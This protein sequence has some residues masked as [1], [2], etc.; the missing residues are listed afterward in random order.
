MR[1]LQWVLLCLLCTTMACAESAKKAADALRDSMGKSQFVLRNFSGEDK[2][3]ASWTGTA[4]EL[5][6][7]RWKTL[8]VL[9]VDSVKLHG[10]TLTLGCVRHVAIR[11]NGG[12]VALYPRA[13]DIEIE[14]DLGN[15]DPAA[16][17]A[18]VKEALFY[19]SIQDAL[20]AIPESMQKWIPARMD[21]NSPKPANEPEVLGA[22]ECDCAAKDRTGCNAINA[23]T[24]GMIPPKYLSGRDPEFS[25]AAR[26]ETLDAHVLVGLKVDESGHPTDVWVLRPVGVGLDEAAAK[27]VLTYVFQPALC[28]NNPVSMYLNIDVRFQYQSY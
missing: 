25:D 28:H 9:T 7:P 10:N 27:A 21:K 5:D 15:A 22:A 24:P 3:H 6:T 1:K 13:N 18:R 8:G 20:A 26:R 4:F 16:V 19:P 11:D 14:V 12:K 17:L 2:V 23:K